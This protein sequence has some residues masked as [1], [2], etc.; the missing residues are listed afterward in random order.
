MNDVINAIGSSPSL[1]RGTSFIASFVVPIFGFLGVGA[2][3]G[4]GGSL[5]GGSPPPGGPPGSP[6]GSSPGSFRSGKSGSGL[7][8]GGSVP[9]AIKLL[10][11][12]LLSFSYVGSFLLEWNEVF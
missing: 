5:V 3:G 8:P 12:V 11:L 9:A 6:G 10:L 1:Y 2:F 4:S 7:L